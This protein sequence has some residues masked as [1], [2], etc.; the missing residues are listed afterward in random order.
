MKNLRRA[1]LLL[2]FF[3]LLSIFIRPIAADQVV[4]NT[5]GEVQESDISVT[6]GCHSLDG[7]VPV[8]GTQ[9][10]IPNMEAAVLFDVDTE[11]IMYAFNADVQM[12]PAS[13]VKIMTALLATIQWQSSER[14]MKII[15]KTMCQPQ[16]SSENYTKKPEA[17]ASG[18]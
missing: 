18:F 12:P 2:C 9:Q 3:C 13:L 14:T 16:E 8:M 10:L 6:N 1:C 17:H 4:G 15:Q 7:M 11:T 5:V